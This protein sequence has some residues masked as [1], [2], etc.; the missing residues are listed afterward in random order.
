MGNQKITVPANGAK[1]SVSA[2]GKISVP[3]N[4]IIP[5]IEGDGIGVD[6]SPVMKKVTDAAVSKAYGGKRQIHWMEIYAGEKS[7][8]VYDAD[9]WLSDETMNAIRDFSVAIKGP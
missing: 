6:I 4:P 3:D 7:T 2:N 9:T 8:R 5:Y 1:I